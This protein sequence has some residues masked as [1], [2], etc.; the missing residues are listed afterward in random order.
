MFCC[1]FS[2]FLFIFWNT[3]QVVALEHPNGWMR[4]SF[5]CPLNLVLCFTCVYIGLTLLV[6]TM[7]ECD[8]NDHNQKDQCKNYPKLEN[9]RST[10]EI[11]NLRIQCIF[12]P[13]HTPHLLNYNT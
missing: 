11:R 6:L 1:L 8:H 7:L 3:L 12:G 13:V 4:L 9:T 5:T 2:E 10:S